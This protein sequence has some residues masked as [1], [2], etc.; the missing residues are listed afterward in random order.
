[1]GSNHSRGEQISN[2]TVDSSSSINTDVTTISNTTSNNTD[3]Q[4][5]SYTDV[6]NSSDIATTKNTTTIKTT[7]HCD[8]LELSNTD[9]QKLKAIVDES[10]ETQ[11]NASTNLEVYGENIRVSNVTLSNITNFNGGIKTVECV[12]E[13][14]QKLDTQ[15]TIDNERIKDTSDI[16]KNDFSSDLTSDNKNDITS[17]SDATATNETGLQN[18]QS[19]EHSAPGNAAGGLLGG[20]E[21]IIYISIV[22]FSTLCLYYF[23]K[24]KFINYKKYLKENKDISSLL[25][26]VF[27]LIA[28]RQYSI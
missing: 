22:F 25:T 7:Q 4:K 15:S 24:E 12:S 16:L 8:G 1:M 9:A 18:T 2:T 3:I 10:V 21:L 23:D 13:I 6:D 11:V 5:S 14:L 20:N 26:L 17:A 28:I 27:V 19:Q